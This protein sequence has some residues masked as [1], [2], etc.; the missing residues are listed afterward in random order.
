MPEGKQNGDWPSPS[1]A[2]KRLD[3][4]SFLRSIRYPIGTRPAGVAFLV[5]D[6]GGLGGLGGVSDGGPAE[7]NQEKHTEGTLLA[8]II[9]CARHLVKVF[10]ALF[11]HQ[12]V[13]DTLR[14]WHP[15]APAPPGSPTA[16]RQRWDT[17]RDFPGAL[18]RF[19]RVVR[20]LLWLH[21]K[22][23]RGDTPNVLNEA[24]TGP[25]KAPTGAWSDPL[26]TRVLGCLY[27]TSVK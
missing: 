1:S 16:A 3:K 11:I 19:Q 12:Q 13:N 27:V 14:H 17:L 2:F 18:T 10:I 6:L 22:R 24:R 23:R 26:R 4:Q 15:S 21:V 7:E 5:K 20:L 9:S 25:T 8:R